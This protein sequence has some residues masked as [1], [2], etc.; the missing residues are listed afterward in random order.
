MPEPHFLP[1]LWPFTFTLSN[2]AVSIVEIYCMFGRHLSLGVNIFNPNTSMSVEIQINLIIFPNAGNKRYLRGWKHW[3]EYK[4]NIRVLGEIKKLWLNLKAK[5]RGEMEIY[6]S[7][8]K[9]INHTALWLESLD[10]G[11]TDDKRGRGR[12]NTIKSALLFFN[13]FNFK[14][15][16]LMSSLFFSVSPSPW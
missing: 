8:N 5:T 14:K 6:E 4:D 3:R 13:V 2:T 15:F 16:F 10:L 9:G 12:A 7:R 1:E 11:E